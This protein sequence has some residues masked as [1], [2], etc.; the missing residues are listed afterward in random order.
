MIRSGRDWLIQSTICI[1]WSDHQGNDKEKGLW[2][3]EDSYPLMMCPPIIYHS[4]RSSNH[5]L[6]SPLYQAE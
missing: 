5:V 3:M 6:D 1:A 2:G 4:D